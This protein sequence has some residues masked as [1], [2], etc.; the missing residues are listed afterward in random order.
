MISRQK[1]KE[2]KQE[3]LRIQQARI[4]RCA[5][6]KHC[7][8]MWGNQVVCEK[9]PY[10]MTTRKRSST[11]YAY[12]EITDNE[13]LEFNAEVVPTVCNMCE[14]KIPRNAI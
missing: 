11:S 12:G 4:D 8:M 2:Q 1:R 9:I 6:C 5:G 7:R 10:T 3:A 13:Q 14:R